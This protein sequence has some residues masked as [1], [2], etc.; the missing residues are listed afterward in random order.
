MVNPNFSIRPSRE[1]DMLRCAEIM[2]A[3]FSPDPIGPLLF[4]PHTPSSWAATAAVHWRA[5]TEHLASFPSVPFA[6]HC[7][8][9][10]PSTG[11]ETIVATAEWAVYDRVRT[12]AEW[13]VDPYTNRLEYVEPASARAGAQAMLGPV[14]A[15]R[16]DFVKG[17]PY[18]LLTFMAVDPTWRRQGAATA[19]VRWGME[20]CAE[21]GVPAYLEAT[22]EGMKAYASMGWE[23]V[24]VGRELV[25]PPMMW[26]PEGVE[27]W[28]DVKEVKEADGTKVVNGT[29]EDFTIGQSE[30]FELK[31]Q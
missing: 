30:V 24:D 17:R 19:C 1:A 13:V 4:G 16:Q 14:V 15:A 12:A 26:W 21:V 23:R 8:H 5:H 3:S 27:R 31:G 25:Y 11:A 20:R 28:A 10:D 2:N 7:V 18:G 22:A 6:I 29:E 9:T